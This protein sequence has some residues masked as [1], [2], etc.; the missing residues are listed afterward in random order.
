MS[1]ALAFAAKAGIRTFAQ[2]MAGAMS[3]ISI[4]ALADIQGL[5][6][7]A[8]VMA[9]GALVAGLTAFFQNWSE[10]LA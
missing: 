9:I 6:E 5:G 7:V 8:A 3:G 1:D 4:A 10:Q 2:A